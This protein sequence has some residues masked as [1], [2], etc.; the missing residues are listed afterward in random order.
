MNLNESSLEI[1]KKFRIIVMLVL[2]YVT[3]IFGIFALAGCTLDAS[4]FSDKIAPVAPLFLDIGGSAGTLY[5][6]PALNWTEV[7]DDLSGV[8]RYEVKI[9]RQKD[10]VTEAE[11]KALEPGEKILPLNLSP[12]EVY[13][14]V[15]R[16]VDNAGNISSE[17]V[18]SPWLAGSDGCVGDMITNTPYA[19]GTGESASPY[20]LCTAAHVAEIANRP[21]DFGAYFKMLADVNFT[22]LTFDGIGS[23]A[24]PFKGHFDGGNHL[25]KNLS[26]QRAIGDNVGFFNE[27]NFANIKNIGFD[28][29]N[30]VAT[31]SQNVGTLIGEC[32]YSQL[33]NLTITNLNISGKSIVGGIIG[34]TNACD[35]LNA[36]VSGV[37]AGTV[38]DVGGLIGNVNQGNY[39][40]ITA[41]VTVNAFN[42]SSVGGAY[43]SE[44]WTARFQNININGQIS[45]GNSVGGFT[46]ENSDGAY[47]YRSSFVGKITGKNGVGGVSGV[48][49]DSPYI[50][51]STSVNAEITGESQVGGFAGRYVVRNL[52]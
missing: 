12:Q 30:I 29:S 1:F 32:Y 20:L 17:V 51:K 7:V 47:I 10:G 48:N 45:G 15:L 49:N 44:Y 24:T 26:I 42:A 34:V 18:S 13:Y 21:Q 8:A 36:T 23:L 6:S 33:E 50:V 22:G 16:V 14:A 27:T 46:G 5:E 37:V 25:I 40:N 35:L 9:I 11:W 4:L 38:S 19:Q 41:T 2:K 3:T 31:D 39:F 28:N 52:L 43:G